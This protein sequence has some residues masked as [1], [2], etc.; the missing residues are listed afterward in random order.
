[1]TRWLS[2]SLAVIA[3]TASSAHADDFPKQL[4]PELLQV[5]HEVCK[6]STAYGKR[7]IVRADIDGDHKPDVILDY[8][9]AMCGWNSTFFCAADGCLLRIY[10]TRGGWHRV[11]DG[12]ARQWQ[13]TADRGM[14][15]VMIDGRP[16]APR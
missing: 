3:L 6:T 14:P 12:R 4:M 15:V 11:F 7:F 8:R 9:D 16:L 1:M 10:A 13:F 2:L 5:E